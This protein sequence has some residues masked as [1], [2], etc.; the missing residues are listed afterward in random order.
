MIDFDLAE[1]YGVTIKHLN[2]QVSRNKRRFPIH[3]NSG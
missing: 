2:Q 1:L 3:Y